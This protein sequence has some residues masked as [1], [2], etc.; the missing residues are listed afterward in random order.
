MTSRQKETKKEEV[1]NIQICRCFLSCDECCLYKIHLYKIHQ[2]RMFSESQ[3][4]FTEVRN[5]IDFRLQI[6]SNL[7]GVMT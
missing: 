4:I 3:S 7:T 5:Q 1:S 2:I 6:N